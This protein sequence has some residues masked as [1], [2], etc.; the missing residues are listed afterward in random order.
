MAYKDLVIRLSQEEKNHFVA[1]ALED[2]KPVASNS[3]ELRFDELR[4]IE[5]LRE[6]EKAAVKAES[7][8]TFHKDFGQ[9]LYGKVL[10]GELGSYFQK[11]LEANGEG[12]R[13]SLQ[14]DDSAQ[15]LA[16]LALGVS[17]RRRGLP[18][19]SAKYAHL[20]HAFQTEKSS[21]SAP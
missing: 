10:A 1:S 9:E 18:G 19:G 3:F 14:F 5:R 7:Q 15:K 6:L 2:G 8:E 17:P 13:I 4:I 21:V 20:T 16:T 11:Q 12:L